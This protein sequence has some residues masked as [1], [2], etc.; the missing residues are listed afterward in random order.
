MK[1]VF[2]ATIVLFLL[3]LTNHSLAGDLN[4]VDPWIPE[5]PPSAR[6]LAGYMELQNTGDKDIRIV[7][8]RSEALF[9]R[10][11][12]HRS[13]TIDGMS[14]MRRIPALEIPAGES[15]ILERGGLHLMLMRPERVPANGET[16]HIELLN[17]ADDVVLTVE[18][19]VRPRPNES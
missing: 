12:I 10:V 3:S 11:E 8:A 18:A 15:V 19:V 4:A 7:D 6:M 13:E 14:R 2:A 1:S 16:V 17:E 9:G 5:A